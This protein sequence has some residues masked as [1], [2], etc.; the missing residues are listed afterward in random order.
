MI[1]IKIWFLL[2]LL[3]VPDALTVKYSGSIYPTEAGCLKAKES[4]L[5]VYKSRPQEYKDKLITEAYCLSF[6]S[7]PVKG[8]NYKESSLDV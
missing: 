3:S 2:V 6:D 4:Y 8:M 1:T 7:F 5:T